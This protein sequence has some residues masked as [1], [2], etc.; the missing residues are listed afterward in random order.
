MGSAT[1]LGSTSAEDEPFF[2]EGKLTELHVEL[3]KE[4]LLAK[5]DE[6][7][8][9]KAVGTG[10]AAAVGDLF[11]QAANAA[12]LAMYDGEDTQNFVCLIGSQ[13]MCGQF[14]GAEMLRE[15]DSIKAVVSR[16]GDVLYARAV[17]SPSRGLVWIAHSWGLKAERWANLK[18]A[19][20][21][22]CFA[23]LF[24]TLCILF[25]GTGHWGKMETFLWGVVVAGG[26][27]L[28]MALWTSSDMRALAG[29]DLAPEIRIP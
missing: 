7:Y 4:N 20:W 21:L 6:H 19:L 2:V 11:G 26:L 13:V 15:G 18:L 8:R 23:M 28:G 17:M 9:A 10:T 27:C 24:I 22:F 12:M 1:S 5:V 16:K 14:G 25:I 29:P 3:G